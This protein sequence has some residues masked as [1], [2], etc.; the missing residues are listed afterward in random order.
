MK[1]ECPVSCSSAERLPIFQKD[2]KDAHARCP[3]WADLGEC[4]VNAAMK[5]ICPYSCEICTSEEEEEVEEVE[6]LCTDEHA[7]CKF[8]ADQGEC[9]NNP[10]VSQVNMT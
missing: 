9:T 3:V 7:N 1:K 6:E 8:W 4:E 10:K 2:C 5:K